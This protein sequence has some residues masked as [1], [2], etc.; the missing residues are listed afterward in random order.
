MPSI[1]TAREDRNI[2]LVRDMLYGSMNFPV[3]PILEEIKAIS[4]LG[5]DYLPWWIPRIFRMAPPR[6]YYEDT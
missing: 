3:K 5:F 4:E 6:N 1:L 2:P